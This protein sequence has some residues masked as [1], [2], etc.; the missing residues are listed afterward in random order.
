M[1]APRTLPRIATLHA[2][3]P[4]ATFT[5]PSVAVQQT[6]RAAAAL[7]FLARWMV[8]ALTLVLA[9]LVLALVAHRVLTGRS[10]LDGLMPETILAFLV[11]LGVL[12][13]NVGFVLALMLNRIGRRGGKRYE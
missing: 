8:C 6:G 10:L 12:C 11:Y 2:S 13:L 4:L 9:V 1:N 5:Q 3:V 7:R